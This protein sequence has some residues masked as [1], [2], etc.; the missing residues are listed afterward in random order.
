MGGRLFCS[1]FYVGQLP[2]IDTKT[3]Q[4]TNW[5]FNIHRCDFLFIFLLSRINW[6]AS[7]WKLFELWLN[8]E[9]KYL[10]CHVYTVYMKRKIQTCK[11][12]AHTHTH[13]KLCSTI[14]N[15]CCSTFWCV[16]RVCF[17]F[18]V[19]EHVQR[20]ASIDSPVLSEAK[21]AVMSNADERKTDQ[22]KKKTVGKEISFI[23]VEK[24]HRF[25]HHHEK[26][27]FFIILRAL[28]ILPLMCRKSFCVSLLPHS[29]AWLGGCVC[30]LLYCLRQWKLTT[31]P[32]H[33]VY[34]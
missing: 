13:T 12:N 17:P 9:Q 19:W 22:R 8:C 15:F 20:D 16:N 11:H 14:K 31:K 34:V 25:Q 27:F 21:C 2:Q 10:F 32:R 26:L 24:K 30:F 1:L 3:I 4:I 23:W 7:T 33:M 5:K 18:W 29:V 28:H 6:T